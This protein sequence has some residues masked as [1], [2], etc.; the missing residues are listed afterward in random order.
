MFKEIGLGLVVLAL[1]FGAITLYSDA[2]FVLSFGL[3]ILT[4]AYAVGYL[5]LE[6]LK[7]R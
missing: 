4:M 3:L 5:I 2:M 6:E 7:G 1:L